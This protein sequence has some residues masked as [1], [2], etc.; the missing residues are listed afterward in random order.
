MKDFILCSYCGLNNPSD[1]RFCRQCGHK[2]SV[3]EENL[4]CPNCN[5]P[6]TPD[7]LYCGSCGTKLITIEENICPECSFANPISFQYCGN[8]G[9]PLN[10]IKT[11][12]IISKTI[13]EPSEIVE[14]TEEI[15][16]SD[17]LEQITQIEKI[18][19]YP[20][21]YTLMNRS[22]EVEFLMQAFNNTLKN[23]KPHLILLS[24]KAG[25]GKN[26]LLYEFKMKLWRSGWFGKETKDIKLRNLIAGTSTW[27]KVGS[28]ITYLVTACSPYDSHTP[29]FIARK[30]L[31]HYLNLTNKMSLEEKKERILNGLKGL[32]GDDTTTIEELAPFVIRILIPSEN[33][34]IP[35]NET[36]QHQQQ[37]FLVFRKLLEKL[38]NV[39]PT[40]M[41]LNNL[42]WADELSIKLLDYLLS[43]ID[44]GSLLVISAIRPV[45]SDKNYLY[46]FST[47]LEAMGICTKLNIEELTHKESKR[48]I[49]NLISKTDNYPENFI[50]SLIAYSEGN[51]LYI[52]E[53]LCL[54]S[55]HNL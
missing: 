19:T 44:T 12:P 45:S 49:D 2:L 30:L 13:S 7:M 54:L 41:I 40:L 50:E 10:P 27:N 9:N 11:K 39:R 5:G 22:E 4:T 31:T 52:E 15:L 55:E 48:L 28:K 3:S 18:K 6:I 17:R 46:Q 26:P 16:E 29:Y 38:V 37:T 34:S 20:S 1:A 35:N 47:K 43:F 32:F 51:P 24:G 33:L 8:C 21:A 25:S 14:D 42:H 23:K 53:S 36:I